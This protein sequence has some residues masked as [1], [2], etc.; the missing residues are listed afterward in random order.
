MVAMC[1]FLIGLFKFKFDFLL[2]EIKKIK[3]IKNLNR[4]RIGERNRSS[5]KQKIREEEG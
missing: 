4:G 5:Q 1:H 2:F 3:K